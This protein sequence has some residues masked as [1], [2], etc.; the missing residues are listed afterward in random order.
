M[1]LTIPLRARRVCDA[2]AAMLVLAASSALPQQPGPG[3]RKGQGQ[4]VR[5]EL[6]SDRGA[7]GPGMRLGLR[8]DLDP[9]WHIYWQNPGDSGGPPEVAWTFPSAMMSAGIEWPAPSAS[10]LAGWS[11]TDTTAEWSCR[12]S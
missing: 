2:A 7:P 8:F 9:G 10:T 11:P 1:V 12:L 4:H 5:V 6:I 3:S